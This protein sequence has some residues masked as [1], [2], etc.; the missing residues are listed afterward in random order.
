MR[1]S[2]DAALTLFLS[3]L[4]V[5]GAT[6]NDDSYWAPKTIS[7]HAPRE[8]SDR[9]RLMFARGIWLFLSTLPVRGATVCR[10]R[11]EH[12]PEI[13]IHAPREGSDA[14]FI[15]FFPGSLLF[16]S[17]LPVR[18]A[19]ALGNVGGNAIQNFYPRSP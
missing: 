8:G 13:S 19:T 15:L 14:A 9:A 5:R 7:I 12:V 1:A 3:T 11:L 16:L 6:Q 10:C 18:G 4:P 17:T 2:P